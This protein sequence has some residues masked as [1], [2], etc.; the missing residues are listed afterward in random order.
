M[1]KMVLF[2]GQGPYS[3]E[4][5]YTALRFAYTALLDGNEVKMFLFE[6]AIWVGKQNQAPAN[7]YN[8]EEWV[9]KCQGEPGFELAACGVCMK[10]RG[11]D[12]KEL[13]TVS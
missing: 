6:D 4:R 10:A 11:M 9:K 2:L 3:L 5:P 13:I 12:P 1:V 8:I 7:V